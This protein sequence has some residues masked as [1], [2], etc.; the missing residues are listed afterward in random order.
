MTVDVSPIAIDTRGVTTDGN[1]SG[2]VPAVGLYLC[3]DWQGSSLIG[4][5]WC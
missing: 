2:G 1:L 5:I 4:L 3:C